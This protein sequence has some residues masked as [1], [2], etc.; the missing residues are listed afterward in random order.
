[1]T[2][3]G[4][5]L[6]GKLLSM[7]FLAAMLAMAVPT[8][9][10]ATDDDDKD[11]DQDDDDDN[12]ATVICD[13]DIGEGP[14]GNVIAVP[15]GR[16]VFD[17]ATVEGNV[18]AEAGSE[19]EITSTTTIGGSVRGK[20]GS[21]V[22]VSGGMVAGD[23]QCKGS[24]GGSGG[25]ACSINS[26]SV[27]GDIRVTDAVG[28]VVS[29]TEN[30]VFGDVQAFDN[31]ALALVIGSNEIFGDLK[32]KGNDPAPSVAGNLVPFGDSKGQCREM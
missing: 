7:A 13:S 12:I 10:W 25:I 27:A 14:F 1:R 2:T 29:I 19:L 18:E 30:T 15:D 32:C 5:L 22:F 3:M 31:S 26:V 6:T 17:G 28:G 11:D 24:I 21:S 16:C 9:V 8:G 20:P 4:K 23:V